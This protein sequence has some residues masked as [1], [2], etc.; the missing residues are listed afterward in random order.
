M[1]HITLNAHS[2]VINSTLNIKRMS[3]QAIKLFSE[4]WKQF[5]HTG[6]LPSLNIQTMVLCIEDP[7]M[8]HNFNGKG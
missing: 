3:K 1:E 8:K 2:C 5:G 7:L 6:T 4:C